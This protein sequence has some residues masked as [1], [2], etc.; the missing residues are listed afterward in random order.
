LSDVISVLNPLYGQGMTVSALQPIALRETLTS[1]SHDLPRRYFRA[2]AKPIDVTWQLA[3]GGDLALPEVQGARPATLR[4]TNAY[5]GRLLTVAERDR[6]V[7][8]QFLRVSAMVDPPTKLFRPDIL[9]RALTAHWPGRFSRS[10]STTTHRCLA[11]RTPRH[12]SWG[13]GGCLTGFG[14]EGGSHHASPAVSGF[15]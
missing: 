12:R 14:S 4:I 11:R 7:A 3:V 8:E 1:G 2:A 9:R 5:V 13:D 10:Q 6:A 15:S